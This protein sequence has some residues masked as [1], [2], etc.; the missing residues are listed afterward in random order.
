VSTRGG[1]VICEDAGGEQY[2]RGLTKEGEIVSLVR[3]PV[4]A[5]K[6]RATEFAGCCFS[7]GGRVLFFNQQGST[8]SYMNVHGGTYALWG[9]WER[10]GI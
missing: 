6:L 9:P 3:A 2:V 10:G 1:L 5:G 4:E 7:P 8:R